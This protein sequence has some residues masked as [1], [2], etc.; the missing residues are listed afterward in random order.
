MTRAA[1]YARVST[2][3]QKDH[4]TSL[5]SQLDQ[6]RHYAQRHG[7]TTAYEFTDDHSGTDPY[8]PGMNQ[9]IDLAQCGHID[10]LICYDQDRFARGD[11]C[12]YVL[13]ARLQ[14]LPI[15]FVSTGRLDVESFAGKLLSVFSALMSGEET[16]KIR[17][18]TMR[19]RRKAVD[20]H[21]IL[22]SSGGLFGYAS[23]GTKPKDTMI[24]DTIISDVPGLETKPQVVQWIF[25]QYVYERN[26]AHAIAR[27]LNEYG[28]PTQLRGRWDATKVRK[29]LTQPGYTGAF[30][31]YK[32]RQVATNQ[33]NAQGRV[34]RE[35]EYRDQSE[36]ITIQ[37]DDLVIIDVEV[38]E[39][40][41]KRLDSGRGTIGR[42]EYLLS[43]RIRCEHSIPYAG[44]SKAHDGKPNI[45]Y[46]VL[47]PTFGIKRCHC[48][49]YIN[50]TRLE[51]VVWNWVADL[52]NDTQRVLDTYRQLQAEALEHHATAIESVNQFDAAIQ[53]AEAELA[54][55]IEEARRYRDNPRVKA[56]YRQM[57]KDQTAK[58]DALTAERN[59]LALP[60]EDALISDEQIAQTVQH[61]SD[62]SVD[63]EAL[64]ALSMTEKK[65]LLDELDI[66]VV[67]HADH[68]TL[69]IIWY[70]QV[71][72]FY[73]NDPSRL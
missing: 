17:E 39:K 40:A 71:D 11:E 49:T 57:I 45:R 12:F 8:R 42:T 43:R 70:G 1:L 28:I 21:R 72:R 35:T 10:V 60:V 31:R 66:R 52:L 38:F 23:T 27:M 65:R 6:C 24:D 7:Y 34:I 26:N 36:W 44:K 18:R 53:E 33:R 25:H 2:E 73:L 46:Y 16:R 14:P 67:L 56:Q 4:G 50:A 62:L 32:T 9:L 69:D 20:D 15:E 3:Q 61:F 63:T 68:S 29:V 41:R 55:L 64:H 22:Q 58:L 30:T 37:R 59:R 48:H 13:L 47:N 5:A 19:G 54:Y 51:A